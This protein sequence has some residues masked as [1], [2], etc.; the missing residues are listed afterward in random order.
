MDTARP[1]NVHTSNGEV[2]LVQARTNSKRSGIHPPQPNTKRKC[3][4]ATRSRTHHPL[5]LKVLLQATPQKNFAIT[6]CDQAESGGTGQLNAGTMS[7]PGDGYTLADLQRIRAAFPGHPCKIIDIRAQLLKGVTGH[8]HNPTSKMIQKM[9]MIQPKAHLLIIRG[10]GKTMLK[11]DTRSIFTQLVALPWDKQ[12]GPRKKGGI[13]L[14]K[15]D[16]YNLSFGPVATAPDYTIGQ[17]T[18]VA[19]TNPKVSELRKIHSQLEYIT[20]QRLVA[21]GNYYH[22]EDS[23]IRYHGD[24]TRRVVIGVRFG[25]TRRLHF[26][27]FLKFMAVGTNGGVDIHDGDMYAFSEHAVGTDWKSSAK[28][29]LRHAV[30]MGHWTET[31]GK[32]MWA[33]QKLKPVH[34]PKPH[35]FEFVGR[36][37]WTPPRSAAANKS[38]IRRLN[39]FNKFVTRS[40][41]KQP[42]KTPE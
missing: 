22:K 1:N 37:I 32:K 40:V 30:G 24:T 4:G 19:F 31:D 2:M 17:S 10:G 34:K 6:F 20:S 7:R 8:N 16:R 36:T 42:H 25:A 9:M 13:P 5:Q 14:N 33:I 39:A 11:G 3:H 23:G 29:T 41:K 21:E 26:Q 15:H 38:Y 28:L 35:E 18:V 27:H 12:K